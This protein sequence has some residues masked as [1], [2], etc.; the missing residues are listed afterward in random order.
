MSMNNAVVVVNV[1]LNFKFPEPGSVLA[2][3]VR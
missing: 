1:L 3:L 2:V